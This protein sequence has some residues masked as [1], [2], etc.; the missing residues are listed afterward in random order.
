L[1]LLLLVGLGAVLACWGVRAEP[2]YTD[3]DLRAGHSSPK[4][5]ITSVDSPVGSLAAAFPSEVDDVRGHTEPPAPEAPAVLE[6]PAPDTADS[7]GAYKIPDLPAQAPVLE[8]AEPTPAPIFD[9]GNLFI[10]S[11]G[12]DTPMIRTWK[13]L[14][15]P[16]ILAAALST[17]PQVAPADDKPGSDGKAEPT[18]RELKDSIEGIRR[19]LDSN[20]LN[21]NVVAEDLHKLRDQVTQLQ[22]DVESLRTRSSTSNYQPTIAPG[23]PGT[24]AVPGAGRVRLINNWPE[25]ITVFLNNRSYSLE[26]DQQLTAE[27]MPAGDFTYE[28]MAARPDGLILPIKPKQTRTLAAS[29]TFTIHVHPQ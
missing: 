22:K 26:P 24:A 17:A 28:I 13:M 9:A 2:E 4:L 23:A 21:C 14:G 6:V 25:R 12:G 10:R 18:L 11:L 5:D 1:I 3:F 7:R 29:E 19:K 15:Y 8:P 27:G 20:V 16:A